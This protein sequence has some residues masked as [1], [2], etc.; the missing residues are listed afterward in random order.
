MAYDNTTKVITAP[1]DMTDIAD[2]LNV[3]SL[4]LGTLCTSGKV[5]MWSKNKPVRYKT[6][7]ALTDL[8]RQQANYGI[9]F[10]KAHDTT[11]EGCLEKALD[12]DE[13]ERC[14]YHYLQPRGGADEPY[15]MLDFDGYRHN[16]EKPYGYTLSHL[17]GDENGWVDAYINANADLTLADLN[18]SELDTSDINA[19]NLVILLRKVGETSGGYCFFAK[20]ESGAYITLADIKDINSA[21]PVMRFTVPSGGNWNLIVAIT[22]AK[23]SDVNNDDMFF[24]YL[25]E[26]LFTFEYDPDY[27][28]FV[29]VLPEDNSV[30]AQTS[31][32]AGISNASV[33]VD[34]LNVQMAVEV[35][36][37]YEKVIT[38]TVKIELGTSVANFD[39]ESQSATF[40]FSLS[41]GEWKNIY[42]TFTNLSSLMAPA[43]GLFTSNLYIRAR[44]DYTIG[45]TKK[46]AYFDFLD[47]DTKQGAQKAEYQ[48]PVTVQAIYNTWEW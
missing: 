21:A 19:C 20:S 31:T 13:S 24:M 4:D 5:N 41:P 12:V 34:R 35:N 38:G 14:K 32:G 15:R 26:S 30:H 9:D 1:V 39:D 48:D 28:G 22:T 10:S 44:M 37:D 2:A 8:Q 25:P 3:G 17:K 16:A 46:V 47:T 18:P 45:E 33:E 29:W 42:Y 6:Y 23:E 40:D 7:N 43:S 11:Y 27:M 36:N